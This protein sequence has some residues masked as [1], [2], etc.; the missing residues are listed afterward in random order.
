MDSDGFMCILMC[1][2]FHFHEFVRLVCPSS[3]LPRFD[4]LEQKHTPGTL[5]H[6]TFSYFYL[7]VPNQRG[8]GGLAFSEKK[9]SWTPLTYVSR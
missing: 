2:Y 1:L 3:S 5:E 8:Y 6:A 7:V 4:Y 9:R